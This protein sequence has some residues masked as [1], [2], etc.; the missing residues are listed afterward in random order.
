M[1]I[2]QRALVGPNF[3]HTFPKGED[4]GGLTLLNDELYVLRDR[5]N[6]QIDI[7]STTN[8]SLLRQLSVPRVSGR[9][10]RDIT[11]CSQKQCIYISDNGAVCI[12]R[13]GVDVSISKWPVKGSPRGLSVTGS[14]NLLVTCCDWRGRV[15]K[16]LELSYENGECICEIPLESNVEWPWH[17]VQLNNGQYVVCYGTRVNDS[18][19]IQ[20]GRDG[21]VR[22]HN[23]EKEGLEC[24]CHMAVDKNGFGFVASVGLKHIPLF[25]S[26][27]TIVRKVI[28]LKR[29]AQRLCFDD[30]R[31]RL[32]VG[33]CDGVVIVVQLYNSISQV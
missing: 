25:D 31:K 14:C 32:Y 29:P 6:N 17:G 20:I 23:T 26:S 2:V 19:L 33:Q 4:I 12:R 10:M 15:C 16:L 30:V 7:Y 5:D 18:R 21:K 27:L 8:F 1:C 28:R 9:H 22:G 3:I 11:S 24:P 13:V